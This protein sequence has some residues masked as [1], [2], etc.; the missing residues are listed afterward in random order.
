VEKL[1]RKIEIKYLILLFYIIVLIC[2]LSSCNEDFIVPYNCIDKSKIVPYID[3]VCTMEVEYVCGCNG[4]T[5]INRCH[6]EA[7][8]L[9]NIWSATLKTNCKN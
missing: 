1:K 2:V 9:T 4:Q 7:D 6:A 8:G 3:R 5:Y